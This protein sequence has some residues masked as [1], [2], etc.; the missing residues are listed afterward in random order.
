MTKEDI[1]LAKSLKRILHEYAKHNVTKLARHDNIELSSL[2][3][4]MLWAANQK[5]STT[6]YEIEVEEE[7]KN[8]KS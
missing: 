7:R 6:L 8:G 1:N 2:K 5:P 3:R 4:I